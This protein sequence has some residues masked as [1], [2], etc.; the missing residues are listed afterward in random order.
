MNGLIRLLPGPLITSFHPASL[1]EAAAQGNLNC[2]VDRKC[3]QLDKR[4]RQFQPASESTGTAQTFGLGVTRTDKVFLS[5]KNGKLRVVT[6][7]AI[8]DDGSISQWGSVFNDGDD[9]GSYSWR[10]WQYSKWLFLADETGG[11]KYFEIGQTDLQTL[12][13]NYDLNADG[14]AVPSKPPYTEVE[15]DPSDTVGSLLGSGS[16][17]GGISNGGVDCY[18]GDDPDGVHATS[19]ECVITFATPRD[20]SRIDYMIFTASTIAG[21]TFS[22]LATRVQIG[23]ASHGSRNNMSFA[24]V[25]H[26]LFSGN[27]TKLM[28]VDISQIPRSN[29]TAITHL[30]VGIEM[31]RNG[32]DGWHLQPVK[33]GGTYLHS[34]QGSRIDSAK[35]NTADDL[36]YAWNYVKSDGTIASSAKVVSVPGPQTLGERPEASLP[37]AGAK[38]SLTADVNSD[39]PYDATSKVRFYRK[40]DNVWYRIDDDSILNT[41]TP[42]WSDDL[43][44]DELI[45][46]TT[47]DLTIGEVDPGASGPVLGIDF[48]IQWGGS[49]LYFGNGKMYFSRVDNFKDVLWDDITMDTSDDEDLARPRTMVADPS[50]SQ[51]VLAAVAQSELYVFTRHAGFWLSGDLP[52]NLTFPRPIPGVKGVVGT[53]A[54][55]A[56]RG[57]AIYGSDNGLYFVAVP[58]LG[59]QDIDWQELTKLIRPTWEWLIGDDDTRPNTVVTTIDDEIWVFCE[60]RYLH[61]TKE[62]NWVPG[63]WANEADVLDARSNP[64]LGLALMFTDGTLG[65]IGDWKTDGGTAVDGLNGDAPTW[66]WTSRTI[67]EELHIG[68]VTV[69]SE[70]VTAPALSVTAYSERNPSGTS[71]TL[72]AVKDFQTK[73]FPKD[74]ASSHNGGQWLKLK[75]SGGPNDVLY[76]A[77]IGV[78]P[79]ESRYA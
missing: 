49:N 64:E 33:E 11:I 10:S 36:E 62:G 75:L 5:V 16:M 68:F 74:G 44:N 17:S 3:W 55:C 54:A 43:T 51:R 73:N 37:C 39:P 67:P 60:D 66:E 32:P 7:D 57:G 70:Y 69:K 47:Y 38:F 45:L 46:K 61:L 12:Y 6:T 77:S 15:F 21:N 24:S 22:N 1:P 53:K 23:D 4:F 56:W 18:A 72:N 59:G 34:Y 31:L 27:H 65:A 58:P 26:V 14:S 78:S 19:L 25:K 71:L 79:A 40:F 29:R 20:L 13:R 63:E 50:L 48:G 52:V 35:P 41:G 30:L 76:F 28:W 8:D 2:S 42:T 9:L